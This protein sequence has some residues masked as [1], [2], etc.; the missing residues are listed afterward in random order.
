MDQFQLS[1]PTLTTLQEDVET[2]L[3]AVRKKD[4]PLPGDFSEKLQEIVR[5]SK[6]E[7]KILENDMEILQKSVPER[8]ES[9]KLLADHLVERIQNGERIDPSIYDSEVFEKRIKKLREEEIPQN[10]K[11]L[12][13]AFTLIDVMVKN[14]EPALRKMIQDHSFD[15]K[16][17]DAL[18]MLKLGEAIG[19]TLTGELLQRSEE[20]EKSQTE[21]ESLKKS[22]GNAEKRLVPKPAERETQKKIIAELRK[23]DEYRDWVRRVLAAFQYE[24]VSLSLMQTR[25]RLD[26]I[27][28]VPTSI[29]AEEAFDI[30]SQNR[31]DWMNRRTSLVDSWRQIDLAANRLKGELNLTL[32]GE[33]GT[34][35]RRGVRFD[36]RD[37]RL[38]AGLDWDSPLTR[39][40]EMMDYRRSQITY[41]NARRDYYTYVDSV[42]AELRSILRAAQNHQIDFEI[43]RNAI[44]ID[45]IRVD[46]MQLRMEQP[47]QRGRQ[48]DTATSRQLIDALNGLMSSQNS[49]LSTWVAYQTQRML[50]DLNMGTMELDKD[51]RWIDPGIITKERR[52]S[53][54]IPV[55]HE[56]VPKQRKHYTIPAAPTLSPTLAPPIEE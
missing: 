8:I 10:I 31:L 54:L 1:S 21:L 7:I 44:L 5:R 23:R 35:D 12:R 56:A 41:Q 51:G 43:N 14:D 29:S 32:D 17:L 28:L 40:A 9:L 2:L 49:F 27:T 42:N 36:G 3:S 55:K 18:D 37:G 25:T 16:I 39:Y 33:I 22:F 26:A 47:A 4:M 46:V 52:K 48:I 30:A 34:V 38:R 13:A 50:L 20:L 11:R 45:T 15:K 53:D 6:G 24:L 19:I